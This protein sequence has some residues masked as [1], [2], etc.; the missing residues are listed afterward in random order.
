LGRYNSTGLFLKSS[1]NSKIWTH[2]IAFDGAAWYWHFVD[3]VWFFVFVFVYAWG[4]SSTSY[5][6]AV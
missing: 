1:M 4:F 5:F 2:R 3:V 6:T